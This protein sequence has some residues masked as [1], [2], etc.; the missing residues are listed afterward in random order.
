MRVNEPRITVI[1]PTRERCDVLGKTLETVVAQDYER[2][3]IVVS[4]NAS[5][6]DTRKVVE[7]F[8]DPRIHY[9]NTGRRLSMS[10]NWEFALSQVEGGWLTILGDDDGLL[11]NALGKVAELIG[12]HAVEA[13][14]SRVCSYGWP[15][16]TGSAFGSLT[17]P[18]TAGVELRDSAEWLARALD[19]RAPYTDLPMLYNGGF[20]DHAVIERI[21][22]KSGQVYRSSIPDVYAAVAIA[23]VTGRYLFSHEPLAIN[24][25]S[26]HST[27]TAYFSGKA[28]GS[29]SSADLFHSEDI[30]PIHPDL[31]MA[32]DGRFPKSLQAMVF[33]SH[34]QSAPLRSSDTAVPH[35]RQ[36]EIVLATNLQDDTAVRQWAQRFAQVHGLDFDAVD[37]AATRT[38]RQLRMAMAA[39]NFGDEM[40]TL[41]VP[42]SGALPLRDVHEA[43]IAAASMRAGHACRPTWYGVLAR[44]VAVKFATKNGAVKVQTP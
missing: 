11:P 8:R 31:A 21:R 42:G 17:V 43:S 10:H 22:H 6:D 9:V 23:S 29:G 26:R 18:L 15:S 16:S 4:D 2:L 12:T 32:E 24:G 14:R 1:I 41:Q 39:R 37:R 33:E 36:L 27:G 7:S 44:R 34:A 20:V 25:A 19:G 28:K 13:I 5:T 40:R 3:E 38:R 30:I 35:R